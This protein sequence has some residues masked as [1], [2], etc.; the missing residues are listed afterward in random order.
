MKNKVKFVKASRRRRHCS[1]CNKVI[2]KGD[3]FYKGR[4]ELFS[5]AIICCNDCKLQSWEVTNCTYDRQV[6][7][8]AYTWRNKYSPDD[9]LPGVIRDVHL[10]REDVRYHRRS[11]PDYL[12][13]TEITAILDDR[14]ENLTK[15]LYDLNSID[16]HLLEVSCIDAVLRV[17]GIKDRP[18][19]GEKLEDFAK[20]C[21]PDSLQDFIES[22]IAN[23]LADKIENILIKLAEP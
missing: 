5:R 3:S 11:I 19:P 9:A 7:E 22:V 14:I 8:L 10:I 17:E 16:P 4:P 1:K 12:E 20:S 15:A 2:R 6:G 21:L 23:A 18:C 13:G